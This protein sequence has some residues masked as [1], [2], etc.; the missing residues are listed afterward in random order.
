VVGDEKRLDITA[1]G[2]LVNVA[3]RLGGAA[4]A[5]EVLVTAEAAQAADLGPGLERRSLELKGK[6]TATEV[7]SLT[8][9]R[10]PVGVA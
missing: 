2:D 10:L 7:I 9:G 3:A 4:R 8:L 1:L 5:G 6:S